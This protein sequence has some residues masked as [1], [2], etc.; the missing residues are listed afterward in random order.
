[1]AYTNA[2]YLHNPSRL[3]TKVQYAPG[4]QSSFSLAWGNTP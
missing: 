2:N 1:M 3:S 4:G